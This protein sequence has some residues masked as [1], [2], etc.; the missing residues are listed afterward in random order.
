MVQ[1]GDK[2]R[3]VPAFIGKV[4]Y[5]NA[6]IVGQVEQIFPKGRFAVLVF[7]GVFGEARECFPLEDLT[8]SRK[9]GKRR[10]KM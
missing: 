2:Y 7:H 9:V 4:E 3:V 6:D 10:G 8:E 1:I 5:K